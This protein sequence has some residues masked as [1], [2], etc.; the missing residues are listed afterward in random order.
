MIKATN[1][2]YELP[3]F[4][5]SGGVLTATKGS[6]D[7]SQLVSCGCAQLVPQG[8]SNSHGTDGGK[9]LDSVGYHEPGLKGEGVH[10]SHHLE[11]HSRTTQPQLCHINAIKHS[12]E[13]LDFVP[14]EN[15]IEG[16]ESS[17]DFQRE[18]LL[19]QIEQ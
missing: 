19:K 15:D 6:S 10:R 13:L 11:N 8:S 5:G 3:T 2:L 9:K 1:L 17:F 4:F 16:E 18:L 14:D 12:S 7:L